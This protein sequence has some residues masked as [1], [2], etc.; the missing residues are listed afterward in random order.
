[1][2]QITPAAAMRRESFNKLL[3]SVLSQLQRKQLL[4]VE[5]ENRM[6]TLGEQQRGYTDLENLRT[7]NDR[8]NLTYGSQL[9]REEAD[10]ALDR[11][12]LEA[13]QKLLGDIAK[14]D[15]ANYLQQTINL[16]ESMGKDASKEQGE[17]NGIIRNHVSAMV[18]ISSGGT[19]SPDDAQGIVA[20]S[21]TLKA[22]F[23][24]QAGQNARTA[25][26]IPIRQKEAET[27]RI[28]A[29]KPRAESAAAS[30]WSVKIK[31]ELAS[32]KELL[33][34]G[35]ITQEEYD[36][37]RK[38]RLGIYKAATPIDPVQQKVLDLLGGSETAAPASKTPPPKKVKPTYKFTATNP[39]TGQV[40]G[41]N[42]GVVWYDVSTGQIIK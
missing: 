23:L 4:G 30:P 41:S 25:A 12:L 6:T 17:L 8:G 42:D 21:D 27:G 26:E 13:H 29:L 16:K 5:Q 32:L 39:T 20:Y 9:R 15:R 36:N 24:S 19:I 33:S 10:E 11:S 28:N 7:T 18:K 37:A 38:D 40:A 1:M 3:E 31:E 22:Q 2:A 14:N 34:T 35:E